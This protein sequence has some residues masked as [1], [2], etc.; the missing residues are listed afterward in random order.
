GKFS[1]KFGNDNVADAHD[2]IVQPNND[3]VVVGSVAKNFGD[4]HNFG[5]MRLNPDGHTDTSFGEDSGRSE[6]NFGGNDAADSVIVGQTGDLLVGGVSGRNVAIM[7]LTSHGLADDAFGTMGNGMVTTPSS[8]GGAI[9][10]G[11]M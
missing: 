7:A 3:I 8:D 10:A 2:V 4:Q 5:I 9:Y 6:I 1:V 11:G